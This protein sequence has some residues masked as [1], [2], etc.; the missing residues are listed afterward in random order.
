MKKKITLITLLFFSFITNLF[1]NTPQYD[2][3]VYGESAS[4]VIAA[5]QGAR[6][7]KK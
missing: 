5:I 3:C 2:I 6:M 7:G 4:G 1:A